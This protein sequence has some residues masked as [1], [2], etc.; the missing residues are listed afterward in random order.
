VVI[1]LEAVLLSFLSDVGRGR[2]EDKADG[3]MLACPA[4]IGSD[5]VVD[6]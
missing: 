6:A 4:E 2:A 1:A 5:V 3:Y